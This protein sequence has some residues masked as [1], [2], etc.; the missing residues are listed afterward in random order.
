MFPCHCTPCAAAQAVN[1]DSTRGEV[2][3]SDTLADGPIYLLRFRAPRG[4]SSAT[5]IRALRAIL[6]FLLRRHGWRCLSA[7][8]V[9]L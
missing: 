2:V 4:T 8:E 3:V 5:A 6:K 1:N 9:K 7:R